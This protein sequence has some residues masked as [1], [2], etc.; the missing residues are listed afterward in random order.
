M[1]NTP[2]EREFV[3]QQENYFLAEKKE[4]G[5]LDKNVTRR[6]FILTALEN[7]PF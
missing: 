7:D 6:F 2:G 5:E 4:L 1:A 3:G